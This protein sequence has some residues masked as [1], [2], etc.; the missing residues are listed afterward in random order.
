MTENERIAVL[1]TRTDILDQIQ[2]DQSG[3]ISNLDHKI[4]KLVEQVSAI[5]ISLMVIAVAAGLSVPWEDKLSLIKIVL[6]F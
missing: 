3:L 5:K 6:G 4:D 1:E 2:K